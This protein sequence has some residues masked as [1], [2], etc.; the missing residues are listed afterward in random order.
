[1][2]W[3]ITCCLCTFAIDHFQNGGIPLPTHSIKIKACSQLVNPHAVCIQHSIRFRSVRIALRRVA[4]RLNAKQSPSFQFPFA[5]RVYR[6]TTIRSSI[7]TVHSNCSSCFIRIQNVELIGLL[8]TYTLEVFLAFETENFCE[9]LSK[10]CDFFE[11]HSDFT[12]FSR[13]NLKIR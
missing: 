13:N 10:P 6:R 4:S 12:I 9:N 1:M 11:L 5:N 8:H 2:F 7:P 3:R